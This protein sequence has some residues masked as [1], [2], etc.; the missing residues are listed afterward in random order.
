MSSEGGI[1]WA[2]GL[3]FV[4]QLILQLQGLVL[5]PIVI[6]WMG[7]ASYGAY[8]LVYVGLVQVFELTTTGITYSYSRKLVS[9]PTAGERRRLFEPQ[10]SFQIIVLAVFSAVLLLAFGKTIEVEGNVVVTTW[11]LVGLL[12]A[13][14]LCRQVLNYYRNTLR[15]V[16][17]NLAWSGIPLLFL[18]MLLTAIAVGHAPSVDTLLA[19]QTAAGIGV[20]LPFFWQMLREIGV[21]RFRL[22][23]RLVVAD[24]RVGLPV[25]I[26]MIIDF[27]LN[28]G[29]RYLILVFLSVADVGRYQPAYQLA[30]FVIVLPRLIAMILTPLLARMVDLGDRAESEQL[31]ATAMRLFIMIAVPFAVGMLMVGPSFLGRLTT[32]EMGIAGRWVLPI[33]AAAAAF[34]GLATLMESV[35]VALNRLRMVVRAGALGMC[36][37]IGLNLAF[38][39]LL[40]DIAVAAVTTLVGYAASAAYSSYLLRAHWRFQIEWVAL[41]RFAAAASVMGGGLWGMGYRPATV[42]AISVLPLLGS[43]AAAVAIYFAILSGLGGLGRRELAQITSLMRSRVPEIGKTQ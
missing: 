41:L 36:L 2:L 30:S 4:S 10:F 27:T 23:P 17:Y 35:G 22:R 13:N 33:V 19:L 24:F 29:D 28:F 5:L 15:F 25:T 11:L 31:I 1:G 14:L 43:I 21:P 8:V 16:S 18:A 37:N 3:S 32:V 20:S 6:P 40:R 12:A 9:A 39:P 38:L 26:G 34:Y 7:E 42:A